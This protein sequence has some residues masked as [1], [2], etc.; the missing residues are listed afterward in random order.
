VS[1]WL[2]LYENGQS[3]SKRLVKEIKPADFILSDL[4]NELHRQLQ[5]KIKVGG[6]QDNETPLGSKV[7]YFQ[8]LW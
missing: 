7:P 3:T 8:R 4:E 5:D 2:H 6:C 1:L